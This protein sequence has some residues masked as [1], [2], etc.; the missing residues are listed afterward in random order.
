MS[1]TI[2]PRASMIPALLLGAAG[3]LVLGVQPALYG[4]YVH[5][6][7]VGEATLGTLAAAE[8]SAIAVGSIAGIALLA[9]M[10]AQLIGM[11]GIGLL[12]FGNMIPLELSL[13]GARGVAGF[14]GGMVVA[15]AAA[16][17]ARQVNVNSASGWF[18]FLQATSQ[19]AVLQ[20]FAL[21]APAA[22]ASTIQH[23]LALLVLLS[24]PLLWLMPAWLRPARN[25]DARGQPSPA[26]WT[27][28][29][30]SALFVGAA[31][32]VWAYLGVWLESTGM[33]A[34]DVS[35]RLTVSLAGQMLGA[36]CAVVL[37]MRGRSSVQVVASG[38]AMIII[39][40]L[41]LVRGG[42]DFLGW[43]LLAGFGF[44]WM[45]GTPALSGLLL[46]LDPARSSLP[47][48]ASAQLL[49]AALVP[50]LAGELLANQGLSLVLAAST[51]VA[52][53]ALLTAVVGILFMRLPSGT[54][55]TKTRD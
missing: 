43:L 38:S 3:L 37:G 19:Y 41:L 32:G 42:N 46:E 29:L 17:I 1:D 20:G 33:A 55:Q 34:N 45:V 18:L 12:I 16:Q 23:M 26:G 9:R 51:G 8:I 44:A 36:L 13:F 25:D 4:A 49:G 24:S 21:F 5:E 48:G 28:L 22:A 11:M 39:V 27:A 15:L 30:A 2:D 40:A 52:G 7:F 54:R 14:G 53:L 31:I 10:R 47:Y 35:S 6:G 50:T